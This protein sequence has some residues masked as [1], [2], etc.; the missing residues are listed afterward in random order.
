MFVTGVANENLNSLAVEYG[1]FSLIGW[2]VTAS[3]PNERVS[4]GLWPFFVFFWGEIP[5][6]KLNQMRD[7]PC[8][9]I[10]Y[11]AC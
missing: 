9:P 7:F 2:S 4:F 1:A 5:K 3:I 10:S 11:A 8:P 6:S